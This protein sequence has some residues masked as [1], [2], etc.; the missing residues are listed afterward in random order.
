MNRATLERCFVPLLRQVAAANDM[1][2]SKI[3]N[4]ELLSETVEMLRDLDTLNQTRSNG[5]IAHCI[6]ESPNNGNDPRHPNTCIKCG[7]VIDN[8]RLSVA[9]ANQDRR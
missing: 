2:V 9:D 8:G 5:Q 3:S 7:K 1:N 6:C 4:G